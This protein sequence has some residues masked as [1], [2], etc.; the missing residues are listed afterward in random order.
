MESIKEFTKDD[1][2]QI[3]FIH[4]YRRR[5]DDS[6]ITSYNFFKTGLNEK[7][8]VKKSRKS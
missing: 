6:N 4:K 8:L 7:V 2:V 1:V 5:K 3:T